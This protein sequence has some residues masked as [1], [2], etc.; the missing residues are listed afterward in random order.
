MEGWVGKWVEGEGLGDVRV[1]LFAEEHWLI[2]V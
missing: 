1:E 2:R